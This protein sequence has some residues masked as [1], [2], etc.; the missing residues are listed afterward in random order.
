MKGQC[1]DEF[2]DQSVLLLVLERCKTAEDV[3]FNQENLFMYVLINSWLFRRF[4]LLF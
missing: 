3:S 4:C 1:F 2:R